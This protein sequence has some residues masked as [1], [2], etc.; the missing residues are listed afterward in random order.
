MDAK[1]TSAD[2]VTPTQTLAAA[3]FRQLGFD[4]AVCVCRSNH[5]D[6][7]L[8]AIRPGGAPTQP[9]DSR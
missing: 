4:E 5:W 9:A 7:V 3:L 1:P 6:G 2:G 8:R